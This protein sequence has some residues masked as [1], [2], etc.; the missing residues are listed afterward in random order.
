MEDI[1]VSITPMNE[2]FTTIT[3]SVKSAVLKAIPKDYFILRNQRMN[4]SMR[5]EDTEWKEIKYKV[6]TSIDTELTQVIMNEAI[7]LKLKFG[8]V[9]S[10]QLVENNSWN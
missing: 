8:G 6:D 9:D 4:V 5:E 7:R 1:E 2:E 3:D 10:L